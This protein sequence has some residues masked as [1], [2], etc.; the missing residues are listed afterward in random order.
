MQNS[1]ID[2]FFYAEEAQKNCWLLG[3]LDNVINW[4]LTVFPF[5][6][7]WLVVKKVS[8]LDQQIVLLTMK[9]LSSNG[10]YIF[11]CKQQHPISTHRLI[12]AET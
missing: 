12:E 3:H 5:T 2:T 1:C 9:I 10:E 8:C 7:F 4:D 6:V 11:Y